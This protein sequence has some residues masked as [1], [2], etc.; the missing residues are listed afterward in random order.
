MSDANTAA[1]KVNS[2][3][4]IQREEFGAS[5]LQTVRE[6]AAVAVAAREKAA[7]EARYSM[8]MMRPRNIEKSRQEL[9]KACGNPDFAAAAWFD[10]RRHNKGEG[11]TIRFAEEA[12]RAMG[13]IYPEASVVYESEEIRIIRVT[14]TDLEANLPYS[15][16]IVVRKVVERKSVREGQTSVGERLNS[17]GERVY[18]VEATDDEVRSRVNNEK[19]KAIRTDGLRLIPAWLK[20]ECKRAIDATLDGQVMRDPETEKRAVIDG[21]GALG[22]KVVDL[23]EYLGRTLERISPKE[24]VELRRLYVAVAN[25]ETSWAEALESREPRPGE[26]TGS[27]EAAQKVAEEKLRKQAGDV[28]GTDPSGETT[29]APEPAKGKGRGFDFGKGKN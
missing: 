5:Q 1:A 24:I 29:D 10:L 9:L 22:V 8:A 26:R 13:N 2:G 4:M 18:L 11:W 3:V 16:E 14:V 20:A 28:T 27:K 19:S 7:V 23:E 21:F 6:T 25:G 12:V 17:K 15:S